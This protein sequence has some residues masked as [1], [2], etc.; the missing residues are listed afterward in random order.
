MLGYVSSSLP[1]ESLPVDL[2]LVAP[3]SR[4]EVLD[5]RL[6]YVAP[7]D[8]PHGVLHSKISALVE[9]HVSDQFEVASDMLTRTS[10]LDDIAPDVSVFPL[11]HQADGGRELEELA[12]EVVSTARLNRAAQ[13]AHKLCERGV[14]RIFAI[15]V[16]R[17][18][19][20]EWSSQLG[21][22][23]LLAE[24]SLIEDAALAVPLPV[25][26]LVRAAKSDDAVAHA[27]LAKRNL[28]LEQ[29]LEQAKHRGQTEGKLEGKL[30]GG[31]AVLEQLL[32]LR[33]G[34][35]TPDQASRVR[36][37]TQVDI[38]RWAARLLGASTLAEV[39]V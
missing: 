12:F 1:R 3:E 5:G 20:F 7:A 39:L 23:S 11:A 4:F 38:E 29:A 10:E 22:W 8:E 18:R 37:G 14:R 30:E 16:K 17:A 25:A 33:F 32:E 27:L 2:R 9:A 36:R 6:E 13:K 31:A 34:A 26:A 19:A 21:T 24:R 15:D 28:V 35:L